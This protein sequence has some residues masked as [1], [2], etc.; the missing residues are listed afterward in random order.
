MEDLSSDKISF[1]LR[2]D[3][4]IR[5]LRALS[6]ES[7]SL[8]ELM[9]QLDCPRTTLQG[10]LNKLAE[11]DWVK[12]VSGE[13]EITPE[14]YV[15]LSG[16]IDLNDCFKASETLKPFLKHIPTDRLDEIHLSNLTGSRI[17]L[18]QEGRPH[19]PVRRFKQIIETTDRVHAFTP[20]VLPAYV[21]V[22][23]RRI[24]EGMKADLI[25]EKDVVDSLVSMDREGKITD[26]LEEE[27]TNILVTDHEI[28]YGLGIAD[29]TLVLKSYGSTQMPRC[30]VENKSGQGVQW[31]RNVYRNYERESEELGF[32]V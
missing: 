15:V 13:Y 30:L 16:F 11:R 19:A 24:M 17:I 8:R 29:N 20:V 18:P 4:R 5:I 2:S 26:I 14:G 23:H 6:E 7:L 21:D 3:N 31:A 27:N 10:N 12:K 22:F 9:D 25:F 28:E 1:L 32:M